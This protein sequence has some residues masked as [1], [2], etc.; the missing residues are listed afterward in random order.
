MVE[1]LSSGTEAQDR[2]IKYRDYAAHGVREYW[3]L[4]P[5]QETLE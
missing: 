5:Q 1:I 3:I 4:D 2:D